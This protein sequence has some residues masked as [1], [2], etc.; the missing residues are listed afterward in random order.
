MNQNKQTQYEKYLRAQE[1][2][3]R[4]YCFSKLVVT[5]SQKY[6]RNTEKNWKGLYGKYRTLFKLKSLR[7]TGIDDRGIPY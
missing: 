6:L 2:T 7:T 5:D 4:L 3:Y 1:S